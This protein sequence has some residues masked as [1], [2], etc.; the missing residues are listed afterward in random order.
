MQIFFI[1][2]TVTFDVL[3]LVKPSFEPSLKIKNAGNSAFTHT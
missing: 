3:K 2:F 1:L